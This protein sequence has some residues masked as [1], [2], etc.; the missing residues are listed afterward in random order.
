MEVIL[1][2]TETGLRLELVKHLPAVWPTITE[3]D[4]VVGMEW[5]PQFTLL[6]FPQC[7]VEVLS[8]VD[9]DRA[10]VWVSP[11]GGVVD[12]IIPEHFLSR[13]IGIDEAVGNLEVRSVPVPVSGR[14]WVGEVAQCQAA[15]EALV[16]TLA[17][18]VG[19]VGV[20]LPAS[21]WG[22]FRL[23]KHYNITT[24]G[25][26]CW[27]QMGKVD[28][29]S[30]RQDMTTTFLRREITH[31]RCHV[32]V[33]YDFTDYATLHA[34]YLRLWGDGT[35]W[36]YFHSSAWRNPTPIFLGSSRTGARFVRHQGRT[37]F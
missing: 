8:A 2:R 17:E 14:D 1:T 18:A 9:V 28:I 29:F 33:P 6:N 24:K 15:L 21:M 19:P 23:S 36:P 31:H 16:C 30:P 13:R 22:E 34:A 4:L 7:R 5:E 35:P 27:L 37:L 25:H 32:R 10:A 3:E 11:Q 12:L 20:F 26:A